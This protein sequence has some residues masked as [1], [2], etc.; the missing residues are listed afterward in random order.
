LF[1]EVVSLAS[2]RLLDDVTQEGSQTCGLG[3]DG[4]MDNALEL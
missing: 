3:E 2:E 4:A 1:F